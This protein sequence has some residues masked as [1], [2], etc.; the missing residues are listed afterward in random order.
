MRYHLFTSG[1]EVCLMDAD[2]RPK[3]SQSRYNCVGI[4]NFPGVRVTIELGSETERFTVFLP[5]EVMK[6]LPGLRECVKPANRSF[7]FPP[8]PRNIKIV[9]S[10]NEEP[11]EIELPGDMWAILIVLKILQSGHGLRSGMFL[12]LGS[13]KCMPYMHTLQQSLKVS[14]MLVCLPP[15]W[16]HACACPNWM[17]AYVCPSS[18][19]LLLLCCL[20]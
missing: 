11:P 4:T 1:S 20:Q 2:H 8:K 5:P 9:P 3:S 12:F 7:F 6:K 13:D 15:A 18:G 10:D 16:S 17:Y 14:C 19:F